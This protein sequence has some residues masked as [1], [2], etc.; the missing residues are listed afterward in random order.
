MVGTD[1]TETREPLFEI[2]IFRLALRETS[3]QR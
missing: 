1:I 3:R 2:V